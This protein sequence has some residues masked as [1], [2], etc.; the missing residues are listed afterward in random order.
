[1]SLGRLLGWSPL[2]LHEWMEE[3]FPG[4][5]VE[6]RTVALGHLRAAGTG[7]F[8]GHVLI[9]AG[10]LLLVL[11][12]SLSIPCLRLSLF[13]HW[14]G[15]RFIFLTI[16]VREPDVRGTPSCFVQRTELPSVARLEPG[17]TGPESPSSV[18]FGERDLRHSA[19]VVFSV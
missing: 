10:F 17:N 13:S 18:G 12:A 11:P 1:M 8:R 16:G 4:R 9:V 15:C 3:V 2:L 14:Q 19:T 5:A 6:R 7:S